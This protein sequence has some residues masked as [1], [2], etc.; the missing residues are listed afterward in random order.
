MYFIITYLYAYNQNKT[1]PDPREMSGPEEK[2][3]T[4]VTE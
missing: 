2:N 3:C 4:C 1:D